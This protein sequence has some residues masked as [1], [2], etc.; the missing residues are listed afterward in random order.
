MTTKICMKKSLKII[1]FIKKK[2]DKDP[3]LKKYIEYI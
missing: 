2:E 1:F 3:H